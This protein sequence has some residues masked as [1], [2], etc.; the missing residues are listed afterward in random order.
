MKLLVDIGNSRIKWAEMSGA[1]LRPGAPFFWKADPIQPPEVLEAE[2]ARHWGRLEDVDAVWVVNVAGS[3][4]GDRVGLWCRHAWTMAPRFVHSVPAAHGVV[5]RYLDPA[6]LGA[7]RFVAMVGAR[8]DHKSAFCIVDCGTAVTVDAVNEQGEFLGGVIAPGIE[9]M[10]RSLAAG[11]HALAAAS[12]D[13]DAA[14]ALPRDTRSAI[15]AGTVHAL[16]GCIEHVLTRFRAE[17]GGDPV[18]LLTGGEAA[19]VRERISIEYRFEPNLVLKGLAVI[20]E[21]TT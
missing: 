9:L 6:Q 3:E 21:Q 8:H 11:T 16:A 13:E 18:C 10:R 1:E 20:A 4:I 5:N 12:G 15:A 14:G 2:F 7:D 17:L 19:V